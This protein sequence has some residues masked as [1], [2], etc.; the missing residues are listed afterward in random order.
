VFCIMG[1]RCFVI[2]INCFVIRWFPINLV[3]LPGHRAIV[4]EYT[5]K[6]VVSIFIFY[7]FGLFL[8]RFK[9][10]PCMVLLSHKSIYRNRSRNPSCL[11][12]G[13]Q[14]LEIFRPL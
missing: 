6:G 3:A 9:F 10:L 11:Y 13:S 14:V 7:F 4:I 12:F 5:I 2:S 8:L 1:V